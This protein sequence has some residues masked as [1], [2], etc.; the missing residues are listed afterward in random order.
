MAGVP[1]GFAAGG[2]RYVQRET[3][4]AFGLSSRQVFNPG[5]GA[6]RREGP[7]PC[8]SLEVV[9]KPAKEGGRQQPLNDA[10]H[11]DH[12]NEPTEGSEFFEAG[13]H[14]WWMTWRL[15]NDI[16]PGLR[17]GSAYQVR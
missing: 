9:M 6:D 11:L 10:N 4:K 5:S 8:Q 13:G 16:A 7:R 1:L 3:L 17:I 14:R 15:R 2:G 12:T